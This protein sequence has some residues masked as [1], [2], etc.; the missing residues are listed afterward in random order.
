MT[1]AADRPVEPACKNCGYPFT[2]EHDPK[3]GWCHHGGIGEDAT[4]FEPAPSVEN[5][6]LREAFVDWTMASSSQESQ[7]RD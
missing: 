1:P 4:E 7:N 2:G 5:S 6:E 3:N